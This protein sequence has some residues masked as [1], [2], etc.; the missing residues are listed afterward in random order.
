MLRLLTLGLV[1][2]TALAKPEPPLNRKVAVAANT[3]GMQRYHAGE[4]AGAAEQFK[5]AIDSDASYVNAHY[6]L[7]CVASRLGDGAT[8]VRELGWLAADTDPASRGKLGKAKSDPDLD[9]VSALPNVRSQLGVQPFEKSRPSAWLAERSGVW[10]AELPDT[11]CSERS[12]TLTFHDDGTVGLRVRELCDGKIAEGEFHGTLSL[13][14]VSVAIDDWK[15]WPGPVP[16]TFSPCADQPGAGGSCF[17]LAGARSQ[18]GPF[19]RG[20]P[21]SRDPNHRQL[22]GPLR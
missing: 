11:L 17:V 4:M 3:L 6:N 15:A 12:F 5:V 19:H 13:T 21:L 7:A 18:L 8:A 10:S 22:A 2:A 1:S 9:Y 16:L 14:P 20:L